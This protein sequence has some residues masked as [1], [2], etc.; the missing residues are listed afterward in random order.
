MNMVMVVIK[1]LAFDMKRLSNGGKTFG[2]SGH[3]GL[4]MTLHW[5]IYQRN[6]ILTFVSHGD[7]NYELFTYYYTQK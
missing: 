7:T 2:Y 1:F 5:R 3:S 4:C 6:D